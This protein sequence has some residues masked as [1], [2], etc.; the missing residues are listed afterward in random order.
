MSAERDVNATTLLAGA[1][2]VVAVI[3]GV[4]DVVVGAGEDDDWGVDVVD[5]VQAAKSPTR[6]SMIPV[7]LSDRDIDFIAVFV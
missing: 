2:F 4:A 3:V 1:G 6:N 7:V 5:V